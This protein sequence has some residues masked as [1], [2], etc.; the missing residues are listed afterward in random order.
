MK[1]ISRFGGPRRDRAFARGDVE[2]VLGMFG[3]AGGC[4]EKL[5][6]ASY[7]GGI[8]CFGRVQQIEKIGREGNRAVQF[9]GNR[10]LELAK[11]KRREGVATAEK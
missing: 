7:G 9:S 6:R 5:A 3:F 1:D 11:A 8:Q 4:A 2:D 10:F